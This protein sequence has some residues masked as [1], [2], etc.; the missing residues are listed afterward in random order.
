[1]VRTKQGARSAAAEVFL[2]FLLCFGGIAAAKALGA[3]I[4][5]VGRNVKAVAAGLFLYLPSWRIRRR[6]ETLDDYGVPDLP[7][8]TEVA[9]RGFGRDLR[10]ALGTLAILVP[11]V[12]AGFF[13]LVHS[14]PHLPSWL[15]WWIPYGETA[16]S[17][18]FRLPEGMLLRTLDQILVVALPEELFFRGYVQTRLKAAWGEGRGSLLGV[19]VGAWF[20]TSQLLFAAAHLGD[21]DFSRLTVFFP[22][23]LFGWLRERTGSI[24]PSV[25][26]HAGSN[27]LLMVLEA[28]AF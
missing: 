11:A 4:P 24:G 23:I 12:A 14:I 2:L 20:W 5:A 6:G 18:G 15:R 21:L 26:V 9:R 25:L 22:S 27:L 13:L 10:W 3:V 7:W 28:S 16:I 19:R 1:M 8:R 17:F